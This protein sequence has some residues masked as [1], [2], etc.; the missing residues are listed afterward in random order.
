MK[1]LLFISDDIRMNTGVG[2][3]TK[4]LLKGLAKTNKYNIVLAGCAINPKSTT[5]IKQDGILMYPIPVKNEYGSP[6]ILRQIL[7]IEKPDYIIPFGD[8]RFFYYLFRMDNEIRQFSKL[9]FYHTWDND[10]F[11][12]YNVPIYDACDAVVMISKFSY[13]F[14]KPNIS[15]PTFLA[16]HGYDPTEFFKLPDE[17]IEKER[18]NIFKLLKVTG[19]RFIVFWNNRNIL[20]KRPGDVLNIFKEFNKTHP[21]SILIMHTDPVD[22]EGIDIMQ[23]HNDLGLE[24]FP[25]VFSFEKINSQKL[26]ILYNVADVSLNISHSEGFGL[27]VGESLLAETPVIATETGGMIEQLRAVTHCDEIVPDSDRKGRQTYDELKEFG[28]LVEPAVRTLF[29]V[30]GASYINQDYVSTQDVIEALDYFYNMP[31]KDL[32]KLGE[33]GR[34]FIINNF[35]TDDVIK[36]WDNILTNMNDVPSRYERYKIIT[37]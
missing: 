34:E 11:P 4:K 15:T 14:I 19:P 5:P 26:N 18:E 10:P 13:D 8:P 32:K 1:K 27:C 3:Q 7:S 28:Q 6:R 17:E 20:R 29:G 36:N 25:I 2:I 22:A 23:F 24:N 31:K 33:D 12:K 21:N 16:Q 9:L 30:P 37:L 35:H